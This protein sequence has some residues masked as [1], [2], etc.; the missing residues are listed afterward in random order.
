MI[1]KSMTPLSDNE[2][3][4]IRDILSEA[5]CINE[6]LRR[7]FPHAYSHMDRDKIFFGSHSYDYTYEITPSIK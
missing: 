1:I 4:M 2:L 6:A 5:N 3:N 7:T